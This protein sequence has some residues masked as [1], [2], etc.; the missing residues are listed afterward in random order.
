MKK[1]TVENFNVNDFIDFVDVT[2][3]RTLVTSVVS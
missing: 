1:Y 2:L 3:D